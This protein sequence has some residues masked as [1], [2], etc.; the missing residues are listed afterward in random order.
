M[1]KP[2]H[3][4]VLPI[5]DR[6][7]VLNVQKGRLEVDGQSLCIEDY[8]GVRYTVPAGSIT[9]I[10][11]EPGSTVTHAAVKLCAEHKTLLVWTGESGIRLY[12][13][14]YEG[15]SHS[16][17]LLRQA[18]IALDKRARL[19]VARAMY[20][21]RFKDE[22]PAKRS[23]EQLR[24]AEGARVRQLYRKAAEAYGVPWEGRNYDRSDWAGQ[25]LLNKA[26]SSANSCLYGVCHAAILIAGYSPAIGF[27]HTG[28]GLAFVHDLADL[29]KMELCLPVAFGVVKQYSTD[30]EMRVRHQM[31]DL[32]HKTQL[33]ERIIPGIETLL[34]ASGI[35]HTQ[36]LGG[37][38]S[39]LARPEDAPWQR[40][41]LPDPEA[42]SQEFAALFEPRLN[43]SLPPDL[44][45]D[46]NLP[47]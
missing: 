11:L 47:F 20:V 24:G 4:P 9:A 3:P 30:V 1:F 14:G 40:H 31:R 8:R 32:M 23:I 37:T 35:T 36:E 12:S 5:K 2:N 45:S 17:R 38:T 10:M 39:E 33:L 21:F 26:L 7:S 43:P 6:V 41:P 29:Y 18:R 34:D 22:A 13:A 16:Y 46:A 15:S 19:A 42:L 27:I 28:Y 25:D 44:E